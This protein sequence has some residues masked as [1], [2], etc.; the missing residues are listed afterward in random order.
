MRT[1]LY[2]IDEVL[3]NQV[4][5]TPIDYPLPHKFELRDYQKTF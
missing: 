3:E 2:R 5:I 1:Q 4:P